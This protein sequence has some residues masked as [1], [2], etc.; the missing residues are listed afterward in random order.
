MKEW[1]G[2]AWWVLSRVFWCYVAFFEAGR[3]QMGSKS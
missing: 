3:V 1:L 2:G